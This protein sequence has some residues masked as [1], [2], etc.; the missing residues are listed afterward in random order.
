MQKVRDWRWFAGKLDKAF[1]KWIRYRDTKDGFGKCISCG[2]FKAYE[3]LDAGHF[4][5]RQHLGTRW[6]EKNV[7]AQCR[8]CNRFD[9]GNKGNYRAAL[10]A[11]YGPDILDQLAVAKK[12]GARHPSITAMGFMILDYSTR[13]KEMRK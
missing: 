6:D 7:H 9:E 1:S 8:Y 2:K 3:E 11:K 12:L 4:I 10:V 13:V 5:G